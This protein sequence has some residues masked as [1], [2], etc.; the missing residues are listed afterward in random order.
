MNLCTKTCGLKWIKNYKK[1][2]KEEDAIQTSKV[3]R[4]ERKGEM[5]KRQSEIKF[6]QTKTGLHFC[7]KQMNF[8]KR[9][10]MTDEC[11]FRLF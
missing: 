11:P 5:M 2:K 3:I 6:K 1:T 7:T 8:K 10:K 9:R 4:N